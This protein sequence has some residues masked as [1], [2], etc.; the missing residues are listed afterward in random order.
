MAEQT[1]ETLNHFATLSFTEDYWKLPQESRREVRDDFL[2]RPQEIGGR[3]ASLPAC[4]AGEPGRS[5]DLDRLRLGLTRGES[6]LLRRMGLRAGAGPPVPQQQRRAV[7]LHPPSQYTKSRS[8]Q[9]LDPFAPTREPYLIV[10]PF[11]KTPEWYLL[12]REKRGELMAGHIKTGTQYKDITQLL[13]YCFGL[14]DQ[15]FI[16][17]YETEDMRPLPG[18]G[19]GAEVH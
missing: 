17:A 9:E 2:S 7:G 12:D 1:P 4:R 16:V 8:T 6:L 3:G 11:V 5:A 19:P 14:Q 15:E 13:V 18:I 10:Y